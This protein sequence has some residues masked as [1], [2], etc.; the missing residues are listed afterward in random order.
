MAS[1]YTRPDSPY[2]WISFKEDGKWKRINSG[3]RKANAGDRAQAN[4][5]V[6]QRTLEE[7]RGAKVNAYGGWAWVASWIDA[8]WG[9]KPTGR[10]IKA[11]RSYLLLWMRYCDE[12]AITGPH[13]VKREHVTG[14]LDWRAKQ[15]VSR[16]TVIGEIAFLGLLM[17][18]AVTRGYALTNPARKL[19]L[20]PEKR[21]EKLI[22]MDHEIALVDRTLAER[23][24]FGWIRVTFLMGLWQAVRLRQAQVPL[25]NIYFD[26]RIIDYPSEIVKG[27][28]PYSQPINPPFTELLLEISNHRASIGANTL[29]DI[30]ELPSVK[31]RRFLDELGLQH[32]CHHGLRA[33]WITRAALAGISETLAMRFVHQ[34]S[35]DVHHIYQKIP[36]SDLL[37]MLDALAL[38]NRQG[39]TDGTTA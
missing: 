13:A 22:W 32:L 27:G 1:A 24:R 5:L 17:D 2:I 21:K 25:A 14:Y 15:G 39:L 35:R 26:R 28:K 23:D 37:P 20:K 33:T 30:P 18:E 8:R 38:R 7:M 12:S 9:D 34:A 31:W 19:G 3:Y 4:R 6:K 16:N 36:A 29:C 10:T 11:Y